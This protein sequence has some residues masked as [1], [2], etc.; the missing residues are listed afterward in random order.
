MNRVAGAGA[1]VVGG[2]GVGGGGVDAGG[3][4]AGGV[5]AGGVDAGGVDAGTGADVLGAR[6]DRE[7]GVPTEG[8]SM[9]DREGLLGFFAGADDGADDVTDGAAEDGPAG[10]AAA[11]VALPSCS[12][13]DAEP[14]A[15]AVAPTEVAVPG[16]LSA[17]RVRLTP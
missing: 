12:V 13:I 6:A 10:D 9:D 15:D 8:A 14:T 3:V 2:G 4:D 1:A 17:A 16:R 7:D 11:T 5:D